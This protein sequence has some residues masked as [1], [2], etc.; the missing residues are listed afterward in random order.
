MKLSLYLCYTAAASAAP[1]LA[2]H[3]TM[4]TAPAERPSPRVSDSDLPEV[5]DGCPYSCLIPGASCPEDEVSQHLNHLHD[6]THGSLTTYLSVPLQ[7][8]RVELSGLSLRRL[9][10]QGPEGSYGLWQGREARTTAP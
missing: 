4:N 6:R 1:F 8:S 3:V 5:P 2:V 9:L 10:L 7:D